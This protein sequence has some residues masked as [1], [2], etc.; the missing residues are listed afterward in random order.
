MSIRLLNRVPEVTLY[1]WII[2]ILATTVGETVAD[3]LNDTLGFGLSGTSTVMTALLAGVLVV[4]F[5]AKRYVPAIYWS[6]VVLI[7]VVGT[8]I[9]DNLTDVAGVPLPVTTAVFTVALAGVFLAWYA[10]EGTLSIHTIV[11][12]RREAFYWLAILVTFALGTAAGDLVAETIAVGYA[13]SAALFA[14][15]IALTYAAHRGLGLAAVPAFWIAYVLTRPLGASVGDLLA[16]DRIDGGLGLGTTVT[17]GAFLLA[18]LGL[19]VFLN[20]TGVDRTPRG[21]DV[22]ELARG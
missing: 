20:R 3:F 19:V 5:R 13:A 2:K 8:L 11:T 14:V 4:Q 17:S 18:I 22:R 21:T 12:A 16:Q 15:L 10:K 9:T 1:F 6:A 7:S